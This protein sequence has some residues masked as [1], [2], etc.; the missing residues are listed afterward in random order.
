N[1]RRRIYRGQIHTMLQIGIIGLPNS[2]K[3]TV[4]NA[5]TR[6]TA[7]TDAFSSNQVEVHT[8]VVDVPDPRIDRLSAMYKPRKTIYA[9][10]TYNDIG[11]VTASGRQGGGFGGPLLNA[12]AAN[13]ALLHVVRVFEDP[14]VPHPAG[15]VDPVR[16][17]RNLEAELILNDLIS[18][19]RRLERLDAELQK[20]NLQ[21]QVREQ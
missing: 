20:P 11:G 12:I 6:G 3:T 13:D 9:K 17:W 1:D 2:G 4:Y 19:E 15:S 16:D 21:R 7:V 18:V 14:N 10:V 5:L 8:A